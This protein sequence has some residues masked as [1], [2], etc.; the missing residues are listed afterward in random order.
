MIKSANLESDYLAY[1]PYIADNLRGIRSL[2]EVESKVRNMAAHEIV[3]VTDDLI[4][5]KTGY[6]ANKIMKTIK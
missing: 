4:K 1:I 3:S 5:G 2:R 6:S